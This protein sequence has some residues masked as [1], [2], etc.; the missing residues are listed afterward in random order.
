MMNEKE[1]PE[2]EDNIRRDKSGCFLSRR[3]MLR[4][5]IAAVAAAGVMGKYSRNASADV[6]T[7]SSAVAPGWTT[8]LMIESHLNGF[9][10]QTYNPNIPVANNTISAQAIQCWEAGAHSVHIHPASAYLYTSGQNAANAYVN[11]INAALQQYP[12]MS[13]YSST[14]TATVNA[15][16]GAVTANGI[17]HVVILAQAGRVKFCPLDPG[18][19]NL[20]MDVNAQGVVTGTTYTVPFAA[21][22]VQIDLCI[23]NNLEIIWGVY[24]PGYLR[25]AL[26]YMSK[27]RTTPRSCFDFY[28]Q[29]D[30]GTLCK[31]PAN[32]CGLPPTI[33]SL[34]IYLKMVADAGY[35]HLPWFLSIWGEGDLDTRPLIRYAIERGGHIKTG[36]ELH[37]SPNRKPTNVEL[38]KEVQDIAREVGRPLATQGEW[39][40]AYGNGDVNGDGDVNMLDAT[41][42]TQGLAGWAGVGLA[43][44]TADVDVDGNITVRDL[45]VLRRHLGGWAGF[46]KLPRR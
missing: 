15:N 39:A 31:Q 43:K 27:G 20:A 6:N 13:W 38:L 9:R 4:S 32:M 42:L 34:D 22:P 30:Y 41:L 5:G 19:A 8:P 7:Q 36:L 37:F 1:I 35:A 10:D 18:S 23:A 40:V 11:A 26:Y 28:L 2:R 21:I 25:T 33:E 16:T 29:G 24:E 14:T 46:E 44:N 3:N 12:N 45:S 17:E